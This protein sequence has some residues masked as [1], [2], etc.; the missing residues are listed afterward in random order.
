VANTLDL[1]RQGAVGFI[2]WLDATLSTGKTQIISV[3]AESRQSKCKLPIRGRA[4]T[5]R[6]LARD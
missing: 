1:F 6:F 4:K 5:R 3:A 2:D